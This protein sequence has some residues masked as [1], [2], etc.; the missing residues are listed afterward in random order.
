MVNLNLS[1]S[2]ETSHRRAQQ[3]TISFIS[4]VQV[5]EKYSMVAAGNR[6]NKSVAEVT[7]IV[8]MVAERHTYQ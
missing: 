1:A 2:R 3:Y 4:R 6:G 7:K 8:A 5:Q